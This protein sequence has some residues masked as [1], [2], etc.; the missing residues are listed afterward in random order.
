[1]IEISLPNL[2]LGCRSVDSPCGGAVRLVLRRSVFSIRVSETV[3]GEGFSRSPPL[4]FF[5]P[6]EKKKD[7]FTDTSN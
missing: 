3:D 1:M 5:M 2:S 4:S 6:C 7:I